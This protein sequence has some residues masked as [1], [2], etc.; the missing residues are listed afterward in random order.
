MSQNDQS[1]RFKNLLGIDKQT[2]DFIIFFVMIIILTHIVS[3]LWVF[4][5]LIETEQS[6]IDVYFKY[7]P[8]DFELYTTSFYWAFTTIDTVGF[9][10]VVA[11]TVPEKIFNILWIC[12]GVAFYSYCISTLTNIFTKNNVKQSAIS[13]QFSFINDFTQLNNLP[14]DLIEKITVNLERLED[15]SQFKNTIQI[16]FL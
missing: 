12:V 7:P 11:I 3:C 16:E 13:A 4:L 9:G 8:S 14:Q 2:N 6:W 1:I 15:Q 5:A 10:D